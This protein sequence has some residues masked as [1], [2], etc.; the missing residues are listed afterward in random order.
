MICLKCGGTGKLLNNKPCDCGAVHNEEL[1]LTPAETYIPDIYRGISKGIGKED[2]VLGELDKTKTFNDLLIKIANDMTS[3]PS[4][5]PS[6]FIDLSETPL[7]AYEV[8]YALIEKIIEFSG[9][10]PDSIRDMIRVNELDIDRIKKSEAQIRS[11]TNIKYA[12]NFIISDFK[13]DKYPGL[14]DHVKLFEPIKPEYS[15][16]YPLNMYIAK[17]KN[18]YGGI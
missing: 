16:K 14:E 18:R 6:L 15:W 7:G 17:V 8:Y 3:S 5:H 9:D 4:G 13:K 1:K 11:G 2:F 10:F 12:C